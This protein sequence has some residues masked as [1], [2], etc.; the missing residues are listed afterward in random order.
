[1]AKYKSN[2]KQLENLTKG[3]TMRRSALV[4]VVTAVF[5]VPALLSR[6]QVPPAD[7]KIVFTSSK[8]YGQLLIM[9]SS[10]ANQ[11]LLASDPN[12]SGTAPSPDGTKVAFIG[13]DYSGTRIHVYDLVNNKDTIL[14]ES[15]PQGASFQKP[16]W[17]KDSQ[18]LFLLTYKDAYDNNTSIAR[19]GV[20]GGIQNLTSPTSK[21]GISVF[22][23]SSTKVAYQRM[24]E[25]AFWIYTMNLDGTG[26]K[27]ITKGT[28]P[29]WS[30]DGRR[31]VFDCGL[32]LC[33]SGPLGFNKQTLAEGVMALF[34]PDG[35]KLAFDCNYK[36]C[37]MNADGTGQV[38]LTK[39]GFYPSWSDDSS[40]LTYNSVVDGV[41]QVFKQNADATGRQKL[42]AGTANT[43]EPRWVPVP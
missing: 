21:K 7:Q 22:S 4:A 31:L 15:S 12:A 10:G 26:K 39:D 9:D 29:N 30:P 27:R 43:S 35:R 37:V 25:G 38:L 34:S 16:Q 5:M 42:T 28:N 6:A 40:A 19:V 3:K 24:Y 8:N 33:A 18:Y 13:S 36:L 23:V 14:V 32:K 20:G 11:R 2:L 17:S 1:M 41:V